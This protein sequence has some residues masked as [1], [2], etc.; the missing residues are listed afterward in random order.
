MFNE[1]KL[2][3]KVIKFIR[4]REEEVGGERTASKTKNLGKTICRNYS[5]DAMQLRTEQKKE[6]KK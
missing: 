3:S 2:M 4:K 6:R 5:K 1:E